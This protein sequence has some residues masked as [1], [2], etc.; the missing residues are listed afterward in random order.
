VEALF[1]KSASSLVT[2]SRDSA[3][4]SF[5]MDASLMAALYTGRE[6]DVA[7]WGGQ[8]RNSGFYVTLDNSDKFSDNALGRSCPKPEKCLI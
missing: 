5:L 4:N 1:R 7:K 3:F 6:P 8:S 2:A